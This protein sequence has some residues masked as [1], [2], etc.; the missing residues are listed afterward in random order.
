MPPEMVRLK[1]EMGREQ[2]REALGGIQ[3]VVVRRRR[4]TAR[5]PQWLDL[6]DANDHAACIDTCGS[7][8]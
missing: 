4:R 1:T 8:R 2:R 3:E 6:S 7:V 5:L